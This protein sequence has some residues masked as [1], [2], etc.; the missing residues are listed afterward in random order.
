MNRFAFALVALISLHTPAFADSIEVASDLGSLLGS[1][2]ACG[3]TYNAEAIGRY[4]EENVAADD[5][6]FNGML[7]MMTAGSEFQ[8]KDMSASAKIAH[9][10]Q[11]KRSAK[12][13]GFID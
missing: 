10:L 8:I 9:C 11:A 2:K 5:L 12:S 7:Q 13:H 1:E 3:L 4:I 6:G